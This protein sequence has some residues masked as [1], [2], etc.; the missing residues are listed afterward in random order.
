MMKII[1]W[2][3]QSY[4]NNKRMEIKTKFNIGDKVKFTKYDE[5]QLEAE[6][7]AIERP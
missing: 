5:G 7:I 3:S 2:I 4:Q 1:G 6:I